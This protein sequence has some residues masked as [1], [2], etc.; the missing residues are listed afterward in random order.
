M[1]RTIYCDVVARPGTFPHEL[2]VLYPVVDEDKQ[3]RTGIVYK[4]DEP[5]SWDDV[6]LTYWVHIDH[7]ERFVNELQN[8]QAAIIMRGSV[9]FEDAS[10]IC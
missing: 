3:M 8:G 1:E 10:D 4:E 5:R 6:L 9:T 7:R 2:E